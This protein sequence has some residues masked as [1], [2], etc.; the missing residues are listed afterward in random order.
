MA[1][2]KDALRSIKKTLAFTQTREENQDSEKPASGKTVTPGK[3]GWLDVR[4][5]KVKDQPKVLL[6]AEKNHKSHSNLH[7]AVRVKVAP[8]QA[9]TMAQK[10]VNV[11]AKIAPRKAVGIPQTFHL[12]HRTTLTHVIPSHI[13]LKADAHKMSLVTAPKHSGKKALKE[14]LR[15]R[16]P[17]AYQKAP[18][19]RKPLNCPICGIQLAKGTVLDHKASVHGEQKVTPS[20][21][22]P[23]NEDAWVS[24]VQGGLPSLGRRSK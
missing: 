14:K 24:V 19:D 4:K 18:E 7:T 20:P 22:Q 6:R 23:H 11:Q 12:E 21:V 1:D 2:W 3:T 5:A 10:P 17:G 8:P 15:V 9:P 13:D 16:K